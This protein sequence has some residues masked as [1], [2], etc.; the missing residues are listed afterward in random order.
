MRIQKATERI[1][2]FKTNKRGLREN[3]EIQLRKSRLEIWILTSELP[4]PRSVEKYGYG[5]YL[6]NSANSARISKFAGDYTLESKPS[7][8]VC[9]KEYKPTFKSTYIK[10]R[11]WN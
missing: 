11:L 9:T 5:K 10:G 8:F 4:Y 2:T 1:K 7:L 3:C 6:S